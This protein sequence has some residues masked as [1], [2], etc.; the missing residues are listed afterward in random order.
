MLAGSLVVSPRAGAHP[1]AEHPPEM[2]VSNTGQT[3]SA[4]ATLSGSWVAQGFTTGD[5][6]GGYFPSSVV[7]RFQG[8][9]DAATVSSSLRA[10]LWSASGNALGA[11]IAD[12]ATPNAAVPSG[13]STSLS[14]SVP[15][16]TRLDA[17]TTYFVV[18]Y[19]I[20]TPTILI[21][22][23]GT[24]EDSGKASGWSI[25][26]GYCGHPKSGSSLAPA[27]V[28]APASGTLMIAVNGRNGTGS[29]T[30][31]VL[32]DSIND[33]HNQ[34]T[35]DSTDPKT[36]LRA[37]VAVEAYSVGA[38]RYVF[39]ASDSDGPFLLNVT[40][41]TN[42]VYTNPEFNAAGGTTDVAVYTDSDSTVQMIATWST[43]DALQRFTI[44]G[45]GELADGNYVVDAAAMDGANGVATYEIG[46]KDYAIVTGSNSDSVRVVD[47]STPATFAL[48]DSLADSAALA[49][50]RPNRVEVY[51]IGA[52]HY[53]V[54]A[55]GEGLQIID[56]TDPDDIAAAGDLTISDGIFSALNSVA[57]YSVGSSH[58]AIVG[59]LES[60][61]TVR[62]SNGFIR[63][64]RGVIRGFQIINPDFSVS[65]RGRLWG[66]G[67]V[68]RWV[69][70]GWWSC[71][72]V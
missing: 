13:T 47:V 35:A 33:H 3:A 40:D 23:T 42:I 41:P 24:D 43:S 31:V 11:K 72:G 57:L 34:P 2:W 12:L 70:D 20:G 9:A 16:G 8:A 53:A 44:D 69:R 15:E 18:V 5:D 61:R 68:R 37:V 52:K 71:G 66:L 54:V 36:R 63:V 10:E 56:V 48:K 55:S 1:I 6:G 38:Q 32:T 27:G 14:F 19:T 30:D 28:W 60:D 25:S 45:S 7:A 46:A 49:L 21:Q 22:Q 67:W 64:L 4:G 26:D 59:S 51:T 50:D 58:Y 29:D 39:G 17:S 62:D 65:G